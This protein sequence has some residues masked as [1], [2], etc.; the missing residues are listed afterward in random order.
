M[1]RAQFLKLPNLLPVPMFPNLTPFPLA[2]CLA[3]STRTQ[4]FHLLD[5]AHAERTAKRPSF[6]GRSLGLNMNPVVNIYDGRDHIS[7]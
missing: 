7:H 5:C 2:M 3:L 4:D 1:T 6:S